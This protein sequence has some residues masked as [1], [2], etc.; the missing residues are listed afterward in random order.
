MGTTRSPKSKSLQSEAARYLSLNPDLSGLFPAG[1][2][3]LI[4]IYT[5]QNS[6]WFLLVMRFLLLPENNSLSHIA[7]SLAISDSLEKRGHESFI[8]V[9]PS[10]SGFMKSTGRKFFT[11]P[12]IQESDNAPLP[13]LNW[14]RDPRRVLECI[15][16]EAELIKKTRADRVLGIFR[17]TAGA[18]ARLAGVPYDSLVCGCMLQDC[19]EV[20][21]YANG[22]PGA[23]EQGKYMD[24]FFRHLARKMNVCL[25]M[26]G[27]GQI[28]DIREALKGERTFLW[29]FP[30]FMP[31]RGGDGVVHIGPV[32]WNGWSCDG[33]DPSVVADSKR[34]LAIIAFGT[35]TVPLECIIRLIKVLVREGF[36]VV[37][38]AGGQEQVLGDLPE[39]EHLLKLNYAPLRE[40]LPHASV[41]ITHGG[42]M[43]IFESLARRVPAL[44]IPFQP[45]Q[46]HNGLCLERIGCGRRLI[47]AGPFRGDTRIYQ[48]TLDSCTDADIVS[49]ISSLLNGRTRAALEKIGGMMKKYRGVELLSEL[50]TEKACPRQ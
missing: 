38:A 7:K 42:Q 48:Q 39:L 12:G 9:A 18:A 29:D 41:I 6:I 10:R 46:M 36:R 35:G 44:V 26:L 24:L 40:I 28:D 50:L 13:T 21:G 20:L 22:D 30:E 3:L 33:F 34:P 47:A 43:T 16:A 8:G 1:L 23:D 4:G 31:V 19:G 17:F 49:A 37:F 11:L 15:R 2:C 5:P 25:D 27:L 32:S 45:E 14:F